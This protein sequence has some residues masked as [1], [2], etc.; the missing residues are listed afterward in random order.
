MAQEYGQ[1]LVVLLSRKGVCFPQRYLTGFYQFG[2]SALTLRTVHLPAFC[3]VTPALQR[4]KEQCLALDLS[5][6]KVGPE[7]MAPRGKLMGLGG[8]RG[9]FRW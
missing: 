6:L 1:G 9:L 5:S 8:W 2:A 4:V 7:G 3:E